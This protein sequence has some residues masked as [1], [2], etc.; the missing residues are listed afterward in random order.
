VEPSSTPR[1]P[2][3]REP[4]TWALGL[5]ALVWPFNSVAAACVVEVTGQVSAP[6]QA[7]AV[8]LSSLG[9]TDGDCASIQLNVTEERAALRFVTADG[10]RAQRTL[11]SPDELAS[12]V[13]ALRVTLPASEASR[14]EPRLSDM[15][16][17]AVTPVKAARH[18]KAAPP[19]VTVDGPIKGYSPDPQV[20]GILFALQGGARAGTDLRSQALVSP[21]LDGSAALL[22]DRWELGV[23]AAWESRYNRVTINVLSSQES[24]S[25][26]LGISVGRRQPL[27]AVDLLAGGRLSIAALSNYQTSW[28]GPA[29]DSLPPEETSAV[30]WRMGPYVGVVLPRAAT[31]RFRADLR[32]D[33]VAHGNL[34]GAPATPWWG[35]AGFLGVE[36]GAR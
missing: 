4:L 2:F 20:L 21:A 11:R 27:S 24:G 23:T 26:A 12:T 17:P 19:L 33:L 36:A 31:L 29:N 5:A 8:E 32:A 18:S 6:W 22:L 15:E 28:S 1:L 35:I 9:L 25:L 7:A 14:S 10:R 3:A 16:A 34:G 13:A 30:E